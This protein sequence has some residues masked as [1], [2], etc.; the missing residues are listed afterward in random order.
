VRIKMNLDINFQELQNSHSVITHA[1]E[2]F[3]RVAL[4]FDHFP[5]PSSA[6]LSITN[7]KHLFSVKLELSSPKYHEVIERSNNDLL[8]AI[9]EVM[10]I[11][12]QEVN[13]QK[14]KN[15]D[16]QRKQNPRPN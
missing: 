4:I 12:F 11:A 3:S 7:D 8:A 14:E 9:T 2:K 10:H 16:D 5:K 15:I 13:Q 1:N 6:R